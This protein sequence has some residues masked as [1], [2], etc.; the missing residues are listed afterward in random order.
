RAAP[1]PARSKTRSAGQPSPSRSTNV[2]PPCP[3][4][5]HWS[6]I[7]MSACSPK[8]QTRK[9][10]QRILSLWFPYLAAERV[11]RQRLGRSWRSAKKVHPALVVSLHRD[12][13]VQIAAL[14]ARAEALGLK[15]G[16]GLA[17]ARAMH[18]SLDVVE[19]DPAGRSEERR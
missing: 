2:P 16:M 13:T 4:C 1:L 14:D 11:L 15:R 17:D 9:S 5:S 8:E 3:A 10:G 7:A 12:N 18:P 19:A 6:G